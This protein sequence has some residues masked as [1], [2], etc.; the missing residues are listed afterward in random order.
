MNPHIETFQSRISIESA[1]TGQYVV[2]RVGGQP[3]TVA[4]PSRQKAAD[5]AKRLC[6][7]HPGHKFLV[8]QIKQYSMKKQVNI[9]EV[10]LTDEQCYKLIE[11]GLAP[12][13][14]RV[15]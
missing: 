1:R 11:I 7:Q 9:Y 12:I 15:L 14:M 2:F 4:H 6:Q 3:P 13:L 5:E 10:E 8:C